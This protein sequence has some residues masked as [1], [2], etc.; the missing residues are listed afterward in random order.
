MKSKTSFCNAAILRS[1]VT[2]F[3]P[4]WALYT[5]GFVL[6][7][8]VLL[9]Q[10]ETDY[11]SARAMQDLMELIIPVNGVYA[12]VVS[13][14][15][16]GDLLNPRLCS[17]I[18]AMPVTRDDFFSTHAFAG[19]CFSILPNALVM[20]VSLPML[21]KAA[22]MA[23]YVF[24][25]AAATYVLYFGT[26]LLSIQL[27]GNR[28]AAV[29]IYG[30]LHF[31]SLLASWFIRYLYEP[32]M[33]GVEIPIRETVWK[34]CPTVSL[35]EKA[36]VYIIH[37]NPTSP[38]YIPELVA[39]RRVGGWGTL[40]VWTVV[41]LICLAAAQ[42]LYRKRKLE[43]TGDLVAYKSIRPVFLV[44]FAL[45]VGGFFHLVSTGMLNGN[46]SYVF[47]LV[48]IVVGWFAGNMLLLRQVRV[49][50]WKSMAAMGCILAVV[51]LSIAF[52]VADVFGAVHRTPEKAQIDYVKFRDKSYGS[53][54][55]VLRDP[56]EVDQICGMQLRALEA[57]DGTGLGAKLSGYNLE[58]NSS[59]GEYDRMELRFVMK[60]G[61]EL[62]RSY[63]IG[64]ESP[65]GVL[66]DRYL[67]R[68]EVIFGTEVT[69]AASA[70]EKI[71]EIRVYAGDR[72]VLS[73]ADQ[74]SLAKALLAD[75][76]EGTMNPVWS[77]RRWEDGVTS[78][79]IELKEPLHREE[80]DLR[81]FYTEE[82]MPR[83]ATYVEIRT[84]NTHSLDWM[85]E[86]GFTTQE[87]VNQAIEQQEKNKEAYMK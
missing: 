71:Y 54:Y 37:T 30:M 59:D 51:A 53:E 70:M 52:T 49:F 69:D 76:R 1:D 67:S 85:I 4:V 19:F 8:M 56:E 32:L 64:V 34:L 46:G 78:L 38:P 20:L 83:K 87:E 73:R 58:R 57:Y 29:L 21:G 43:V 63:Y 40:A 31:L 33:Y 35:M 55:A 13:Q 6:I 15:L 61:S 36:Y 2:R 26:A 75:C 79:R 11:E 45:M 41:G 5:V 60:D 14:A 3:F 50:R 25:I 7:Q 48:G 18:H 68:P 62:V 27:A 24:V 74:E 77:F 65:D 16:F 84:S 44:L 86:H 17:S 9:G 80:T 82:E 28:I 12:L 66:A 42:I 10:C 39:I 23:M 81:D 47:L 22:P 72:G